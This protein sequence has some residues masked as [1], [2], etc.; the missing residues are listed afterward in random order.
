MYLFD[1]PYQYFNEPWP[2]IVIENVLPDDVA[3]YMLKN[4]PEGQP[5]GSWVRNFGAGNDDPVHAKFERVNFIERTDDI[6]KTSAEIF[7]DNDVF[8]CDLD[9]LIYRDLKSDESYLVRDWHIDNPEKKYHGMLYIGSGKD[10][11]FVARHDKTGL[12]K[13]YEYKHNRF[14]W[15]RNTPET[16]H[17]FYSG[18][19]SRKTI[20]I[21]ADFIG[22]LHNEYYG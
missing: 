4:W 19:G 12:E 10:A 9:G 15:W 8:D 18:T 20:S 6:L 14:L 22:E 1:R 3:D 11:S 17:K 5:Y 21:S 13:V 2:H 7:G 16:M